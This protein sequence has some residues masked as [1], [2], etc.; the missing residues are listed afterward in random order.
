MFSFIKIALIMV[1]FHS[2]E[3]LIKREVGS[4]DL[5]IAVIGLTM[6]LFG[7]IGILGL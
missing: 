5:D 4:R 2:N 6:L 7:G 1:S 3:T